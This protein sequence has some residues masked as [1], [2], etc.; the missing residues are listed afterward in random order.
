VRTKALPQILGIDLYFVRTKF[1]GTVDVVVEPAAVGVKIK[2]LGV[3]FSRNSADQNKS[4]REKLRLVSRSTSP[5]FGVVKM[6]NRGFLRGE[7]NLP[8]KCSAHT[9]S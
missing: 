5:I 7:R 8:Q 6:I 2:R 9:G 4:L 1:W 3:M